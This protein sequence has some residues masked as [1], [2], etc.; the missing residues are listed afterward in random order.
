MICKM[1][2]VVKK[3][4][5]LLLAMLSVSGFYGCCFY[6]LKAVHLPPDIKTVSIHY[7]P[8]QAPKVNPA[9]SQLLMD[10]MRNKFLN[11]SN[12]K[13]VDKNG[14]L[15]FTGVITDYTITAVGRSGNI[16]TGNQL[17]ISVKMDYVNHKKEKEKWSQTF[18]KTET[19][20]ASQNLSAIEN[21][22]ATDICK[23]LVDDIYN[24]SV[25]NW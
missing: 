22:I 6:S 20:D 25:V 7:I 14:D 8:N 17:S 1:N 13:I 5:V 12:L 10:A 9:L 4:Y 3:I 16:S 2:F 18:T 21:T 19:F 11:E 15:D 24:K 23:M